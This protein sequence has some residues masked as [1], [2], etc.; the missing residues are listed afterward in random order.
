[1]ADGVWLVGW[2]AGSCRALLVELVQTLSKEG[3]ASN[4]ARWNESMRSFP[5]PRL[6]SYQPARCRIHTDCCHCSQAAAQ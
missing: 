1:M 3:S 4:A 6:P 2:Y 5:T